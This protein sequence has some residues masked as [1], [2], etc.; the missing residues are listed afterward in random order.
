ML[1]FP[2]LRIGVKPLPAPARRPTLL[3]QFIRALICAAKFRGADQGVE[4]ALVPVAH[5]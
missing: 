4:P 3:V 2:Y 1:R 5:G